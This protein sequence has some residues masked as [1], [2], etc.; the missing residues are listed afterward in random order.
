MISLPFPFEREEI[1]AATREVLELILVLSAVFFLTVIVLARGIG[2]MIVAPIRKL[3]DG[4]REASLGNL[5][6]SLEYRRR[7]EMRTLFDGFNAM[8][9]SLKDHQRELADLGKKAAWAEMARKVAHEIKNPLTPIQLSAEHLLRVFE[10]KREDFEPALARIAVLHRQRGRKPPPH[11][12]GVPGDLARGR[13]AAGAARLWTSSSG[14]PS[15]PT[16]TS[17]RGGSLSRSRSKARISASTATGT[18]SR[19]PCATS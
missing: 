17:S 4:T 12:P 19:S 14:R 10:D 15:T 13:S 1:A 9:R 6:F 7:D 11:R 16:R 2:S 8:I 5:D 18:S 3:L